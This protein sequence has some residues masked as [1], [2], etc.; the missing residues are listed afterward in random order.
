MN[1]VSPSSDSD[2]GLWLVAVTRARMGSANQHYQRNELVATQG[3]IAASP[4]WAGRMACRPKDG[5]KFLQLEAVPLETTMVTGHS[6]LQRIDYQKSK[7]EKPKKVEKTI[8]IKEVAHHVNKIPNYIT[9]TYSTKVTQLQLLKY[10]NIVEKAAK[11]QDC[12]DPRTL[13]ESA[14]GLE[15]SRTYVTS[16]QAFQSDKQRLEDQLQEIIFHYEKEAA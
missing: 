2:S 13:H 5:S 15:A 8:S 10:S 7:V 9:T 1:H 6:Q 4:K 14:D 12:S 3:A 16:S 11:I